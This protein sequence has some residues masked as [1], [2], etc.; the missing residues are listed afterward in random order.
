MKNLAIFI[1]DILHKPIKN[2]RHFNGN[3]LIENAYKLTEV[4]CQKIIENSILTDN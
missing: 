2:T 1:C 4:N 3:M